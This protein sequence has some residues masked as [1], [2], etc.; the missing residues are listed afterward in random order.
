M[1]CPVLYQSHKDDSIMGQ[2]RDLFARASRPASNVNWRE[3]IALLFS[4]TTDPR[5]DL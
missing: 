4:A 1:H 3:V 5:E 2:V